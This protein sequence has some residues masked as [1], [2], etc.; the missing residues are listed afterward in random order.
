MTSDSRS[1]LHRASLPGERHLVVYLSRVMCYINQCKNEADY[2]YIY[3]DYY[4][5]NASLRLECSISSHIFHPKIAYPKYNTRTMFNKHNNVH[6]G[7]HRDQHRISLLTGQNHG[8]KL[9]RLVPFFGSILLQTSLAVYSVAVCG[10]RVFLG[11]CRVIYWSLLLPGT[12][13]PS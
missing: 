13:L 4:H 10:G 5:T 1:I 11:E 8:C 6:P 3:T 12:C 7:P 2:L 9:W